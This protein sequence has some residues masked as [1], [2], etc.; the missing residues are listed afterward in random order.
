MGKF[1]TFFVLEYNKLSEYD[2]LN[3]TQEGLQHVNNAA[4]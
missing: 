3:A 4:E 1:Q 2:R